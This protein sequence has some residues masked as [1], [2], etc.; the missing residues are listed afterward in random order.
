MLLLHQ[1]DAAHM[2]L[3]RYERPSSVCCSQV[4]HEGLPNVHR[5]LVGEDAVQKGKGPGH[6]QTHQG[7]GHGAW[8]GGYPVYFIILG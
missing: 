3:V 1:G 4:G 5:A 2:V 6:R 8:Y 7:R